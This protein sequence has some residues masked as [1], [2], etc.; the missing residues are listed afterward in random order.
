MIHGTRRSDFTSPSGNSGAV[1]TCF[2][3]DISHWWL[4]I[5]VCSCHFASGIWKGFCHGPTRLRC[6]QWFHLPWVLLSS[7]LSH[8]SHHPLNI[9]IPLNSPKETLSRLLYISSTWLL[10]LFT[11]S[12]V[13]NSDRH[14]LDTTTVSAWNRFDNLQWCNGIVTKW[15]EWCALCWE[16]VF[17]SRMCVLLYIK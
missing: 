9:Q 1:D 16:T 17:L 2:L 3:A 10:I 15:K 5:W 6:Q 4:E 11:P 13:I 8:V 7:V 12:V 14:R